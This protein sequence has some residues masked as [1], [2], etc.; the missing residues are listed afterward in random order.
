MLLWIKGALSP[1]EIC[2]HILDGGSDFK[3]KIIAWLEG[4]HSG[5]FFNGNKEDVWSAVDKMSDTK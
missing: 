5:D 4:S 1:Q 3:K 2:D